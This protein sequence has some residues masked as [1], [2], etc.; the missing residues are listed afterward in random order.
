MEKLIQTLIGIRV[1][2]EEGMAPA[3][4]PVA[5]DREVYLLSDV[6]EAMGLDREAILGGQALAFIQRDSGEL[7]PAFA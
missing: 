3:E 2:L 1:E 5:A 4:W 6:C 7:E